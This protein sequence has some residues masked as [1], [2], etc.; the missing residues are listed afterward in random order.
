MTTPSTDSGLIDGL[1]R[2][3]NRIP[4]GWGRWISC[5]PGWYALLVKL[6]ED[7]SALV[8]DYEVHQVKEKYGTLRF[9]VGF[10]HIEPECCLVLKTKDPRP[11]DEPVSGPWVPKDR[12]AE[13][14]AALDAWFQ[15]WLAHSTTAEHKKSCADLEFDPRVLSRRAAGPE[16]YRLIKA[17]EEASASICEECSRPGVLAVCG[18]WFKTLC[19]TCATALDYVFVSELEEDLG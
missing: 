11:Y 9:Y 12:P 4:P 15:R 1:E 10:P 13:I 7:L 8:P 14:Q 19:P 2:I 16:T 18:G 3:K 6:D 17:A 5:G